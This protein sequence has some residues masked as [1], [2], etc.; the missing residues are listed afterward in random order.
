M[1]QCIKLDQQT[2]QAL[3]P[4]KYLKIEQYADNG[5]TCVILSPDDDL[6]QLTLQDVVISTNLYQYTPLPADRFYGDVNNEPKLLDILCQHHYCAR[7]GGHDI[8]G[9]VDY[10]IMQLIPQNKK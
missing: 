6:S 2:R 7:T 3:A 10:P 4:F 1:C 5:A 8:S 9:F